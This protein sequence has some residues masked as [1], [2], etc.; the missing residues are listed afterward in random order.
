M[1]GNPFDRPGLALIMSKSQDIMFSIMTR[2]A[3]VVGLLRHEIVK[4]PLPGR[5]AIVPLLS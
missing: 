2:G 4:I 5:H 1:K 3:S